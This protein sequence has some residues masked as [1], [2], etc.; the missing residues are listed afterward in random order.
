MKKVAALGILGFALL[1]VAIVASVAGLGFGVAAKVAIAILW[2][3]GLG[4]MTFAV[5]LLV[6][7][8]RRM[9]RRARDA[10]AGQPSSQANR[11]VLR[12][13]NLDYPQIAQDREGYIRA[14]LS[15]MAKQIPSSNGSHHFEKIPA[16]VAI[17]CDEFMYNFYKDVFTKVIYL[18]PTGYAEILD[19]EHIDA[20]WYVTGWRGLENDEWR[21]ITHAAGPHGAFLDIRRIA[22][23]KGIPFVFQSDEDPPNFE[24]FLPI[25]AE[26]DVIFTSDSDSIPTY[27]ERLGHD[28]VYYGEYGV[29]PF[30]NNP[31]GSRRFA[32]QTA[33]FAGSY[34]ERYPERTQDMRNVFD[35]LLDE[36]N[37][38][39]SLLI[40]DRNY[41]NPKYKFP[42]EYVSY[43]ISPVDHTEL[44]EIHK[45]FDYSMNF[46]SVKDSPTMCAA[47]VY[48]LQAQGKLLLSNYS[49]SVFNRHPWVKI[50][51]ERTNL[52]YLFTDDYL[53]L[54]D[55]MAQQAI[56]WV[57]SDRTSFEVVTEM[58]S[59]IGLPP[60]P[61]RSRHIVVIADGDFETVQT[62]FD[63]QVYSHATLVASD[64]PQL[65]SLL[66][67][68]GYVAVM[69]SEFS[70]GPTYLTGRVNA[71]KYT[72]S[73][74]VTQV[75][76][77][78]GG[79]TSEGQV[80]EYTDHATK[81]ALTMVSTADADAVSFA[82]GESETLTGAGYLVDPYDVDF[83]RYLIAANPP[84]NGRGPALTVVVPV[85]NNGLYL[86]S[87]ALPSL[88]TNSLWSQM[89]ILL[90]DDGS[91]DQLTL[92]IQEDLARI[93]PNIQFFSFAD[94]GSG[95]ASRPRNKG[96][97][98]ATAELVTFLDPDN[99]ISP[100]GY[101]VLVRRYNTERRSGEAIDFVSGYQAKVAKK[102]GYTG[103][104]AKS[105]EKIVENFKETYFDRGTFPVVST[106]AAVI[107]RELLN[108]ANLRFVEKAAGQD[109][110]FGWELL[111]ES[112]RGIFTDDAFLIY[113]AERTDSVTN[114]IDVAYFK[115]AL[116]N[117]ERK[118]DVLKKHNLLDI[119][120]ESH[121]SNYMTN[122]FMPRLERVPESD[123]D[124]AVAVLEEIS[125]LY[126]STL[127]E[128]P[129]EQD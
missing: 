99:E 23:E 77:Y 15:A 88:R 71:F 72:N 73:T 11:A 9:A 31:I 112:E 39:H 63:R 85:Y 36:G 42:N 35:G 44:Q 1:I 17:I 81:R 80:H 102:T 70:Y 34:P 52:A 117:E 61:A 97:E 49:Q 127:D 28:R 98:M 16:T 119:Y 5:L 105:G 100:H 110:L 125:R 46:N 45:I 38:E 59:K 53:L 94:G 69:S 37:P 65:D 54:A 62:S 87:K 55:I 18:K 47:R 121:L 14:L 32:E 111:L 51:P 115:K 20:L 56:H 108:R 6:R 104:H 66:A 86:V 50:I 109:T 96:I 78:L 41:G 64:D 22:A 118:V 12:D 25:A 29:N 67:S 129:H 91:T 122:W 116:V 92:Q 106:Q 60:A 107:S 124:E 8:A 43:S 82:R 128:L 126:D 113:Y 4:I 58:G 95:S 89:E 123:R 13:P 90:I 83:D 7:D 30:F 27:R 26:A 19:S 103:R 3:A 75:G 2:I 120:K 79:T 68:A 101:D 57:M 33:F 84:L 40:A 48:Q 24:H 74:F 93:F 76:G 114:A 10:G 21:G